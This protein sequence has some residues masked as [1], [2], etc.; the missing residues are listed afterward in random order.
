V[1]KRNHPILGSAHNECLSINLGRQPCLFLHFDV[2]ALMFTSG[3]YTACR[4]LQPW[5]GD[6]DIHRLSIVPLIY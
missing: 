4:A 3:N 6:S 1:I 2:S 5:S